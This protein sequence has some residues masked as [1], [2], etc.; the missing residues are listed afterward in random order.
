M[1]SGSARMKVQFWFQVIL[2]ARLGAA[3]WSGISDCD[4]TFNYWEPAHFMLYGHGLQTW[5]YQVFFR[6]SH[7][8]AFISSAHVCPALVSLHRGSCCSW[9][10]LQSPP[11]TQP[12][13]CLLLPQMHVWLFIGSLRGP[14]PIILLANLYHSFKVY[15][16]RGVLCEFGANV[17][18]ICL[19]LLVFSAGMFISSTAFLPS[20]T[21]MYFCL[22]SMGAWFHQKYHLAIFTTAL[23]TFLSKCQKPH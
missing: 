21:S 14:L 4:E 15:F 10:D 13:A 16:Y 20:T 22:L 19:A 5:E 1:K 6:K 2:S 11:P 17:G 8:H 9:V 7:W 18:R 23:S 12:N 3:V